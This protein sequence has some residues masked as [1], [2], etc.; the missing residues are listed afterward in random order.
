MTN[1]LSL[2]Y[3]EDDLEIIDNVLFFLKRYFT[4]IYIAHDGEKAL[5]L[6]KR[7]KPDV[8]IL[9]ISIPKINGLKLAAKIREEDKDTPIIFITAY[10]EKEKLLEA[11]NL[12]V[13]SYIVKPLNIEK[14][15]SI[16]NKCTQYLMDINKI[17]D[18][19]ILSDGFSWDLNKKNLYFKDIKITLTKNEILLIELFISNESR[20]FTIDDIIESSFFDDNIK[21]NT[22]IQLL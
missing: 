8:I 11:I 18:K 5:E 2:L 21:S 1:N 12:Q 9:D 3:V 6:F 14:L 16:I 22:I 17:N 4:H 7:N 19:K 13:F 15:I 20:V 10:N